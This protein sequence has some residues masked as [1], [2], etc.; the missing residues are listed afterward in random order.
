MRT[1]STDATELMRRSSSVRELTSIVDPS[2][3]MSLRAPSSTVPASRACS[4]SRDSDDSEDERYSYLPFSAR[5]D[6]AR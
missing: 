3:A 2:P 1:E 4:T 6:L 5:M